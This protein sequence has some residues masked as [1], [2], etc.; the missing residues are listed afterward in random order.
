MPA[1]RKPIQQQIADAIKE[2]VVADTTQEV[3]THILIHVD[4]IKEPIDV[5][6]DDVV[7]PDALHE[8][9]HG[10]MLDVQT[11]L[12]EAPPDQLAVEM[13]EC[14][15]CHMP[16]G[17]RCVSTST[18]SAGGRGRVPHSERMKLTRR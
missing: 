17:K 7:V 5:L 3:V 16:K 18:P 10:I 8:I 12:A 15:K 11:I 2:G 9:A 6:P 14:P 13:Y 1:P 4:G